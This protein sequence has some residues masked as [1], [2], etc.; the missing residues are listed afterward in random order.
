[1]RAF[2]CCL[3]VAAP[4]LL[5]A[6]DFESQVIAEMNLA[7][8]Q[9]QAYAGIVAASA[10]THRGPEGQSAVDEAVRF[11]RRARPLSALRE[12]DGIAEA[13]Q[14]HVDDQGSRAARGHTGSD[15]S[16]PW[17]RMARYGA[18]SGRSGENIHY[19][20]AGARAVVVALIIDDGV[21]G[22]GHRKNIFSSAFTVAGV[23][24][25]G[26]ARYGRMCVIDYAGG[27]SEGASQKLATQTRTLRP[28][29]SSRGVL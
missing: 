28:W 17:D 3:L 13:A 7:R 26:H 6:G 5:F 10:S 9:P 25:G 21:R 2:L 1:M 20:R 24:T 11:L 23:A 4:A 8:T 27:F 15:R 16:T 14:D 18:W 19:G 12:S 22:R 29:T